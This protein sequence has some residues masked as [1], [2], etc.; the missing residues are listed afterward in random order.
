MSRQIGVQGEQEDKDI[1]KH[2]IIS[3]RAPYTKNY[4]VLNV[5]SASKE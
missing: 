5:S 1:D 4:P 3:R 2:P